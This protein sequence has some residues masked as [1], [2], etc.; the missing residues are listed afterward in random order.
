MKFYINNAILSPPKRLVKVLS[1][2]SCL[3]YTASWRIYASSPPFFVG[4]Q[5]QTATSNAPLLEDKKIIHIYIISKPRLQVILKVLQVIGNG[6]G[7]LCLALD[8]IYCNSVCNL[9]E[10]ET[11][12]EI[13]VE[14]SLNKMKPLVLYMIKT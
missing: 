1:G 7:S 3:F 8:L 14:Y 13:D 4:I 12:G 2:S 5:S 10:S 9:N 11:V 6:E